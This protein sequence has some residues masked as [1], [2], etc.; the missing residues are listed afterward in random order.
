ME[1][2]REAQRIS[3][4][5][6]GAVGIGSGVASGMAIGSMIAPGIGTAI[7]GI[8]GGLLSA[9]GMAGDIAMNEKLYN[10]ALDYKKDA[11]EYQMGNIKALPQSLAKTS[12]LSINNKIWPFIQ[13]YKCSSAESEALSRKIQYSGMT[14]G[15]IGTIS[16]FIG[17]EP[18]FLQARLIRLEGLEDDYHML[19]EI[20]AEI[21]KGVFI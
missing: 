7:G 3:E 11:F 17:N 13:Y 15:R 19:K 4:I 2:T 1:T 10:E 5:V 12:A 14:V 9:G 21:Y 8:T 6:G 18:Q 20:A 16:E